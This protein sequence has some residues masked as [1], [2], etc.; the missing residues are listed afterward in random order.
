MHISGLSAYLQFL[1]V[2]VAFFTFASSCFHWEPGCCELG[3]TAVESLKM[4]CRSAI[5]VS[6]WWWICAM[7]LSIP[8]QILSAAQFSWPSW[9][10]AHKLSKMCISVSYMHNQNV[11]F[12]YNF[13]SQLT[14]SNI[15]WLF[16]W[17]GCE[18]VN[19]GAD[20]ELGYLFLIVSQSFWLLFPR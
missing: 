12:E 15:K 3:G 11:N 10:G 9:T 5:F 18:S 6:F 4:C 2:Q 8:N 14:I 13:L 7:F 17:I 16:C 19:V 1:A 20:I